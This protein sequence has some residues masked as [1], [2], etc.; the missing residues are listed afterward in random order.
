[1]LSCSGVDT[2]VQEKQSDTPN[3][4]SPSGIVQ[5]STAN[6]STLPPRY[7]STTESWQ[8]D[9]N[10][11][12]SSPEECP[13]S[14]LVS[15][16]RKHE[17]KTYES[18]EEMYITSLDSEAAT[19]RLIAEVIAVQSRLED[20]KLKP[21]DF[22]HIFAVPQNPGSRLEQRSGVALT[23]SKRWNQENHCKE[24]LGKFPGRTK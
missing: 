6:P 1:M 7:T 4:S 18:E 22:R 9:R 21:L 15:P 2:L 17:D 24:Q 19:T 16:P 23:P 5:R 12:P 10:L 20:C 3:A 8:E 13:T 11:E 14:P